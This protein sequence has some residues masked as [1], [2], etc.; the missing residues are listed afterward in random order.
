MLSN[1]QVDKI[2]K[3]AVSYWSEEQQSFVCDCAI[4]RLAVGR[5]ETPQAAR[6]NFDVAV[7]SL[8]ATGSAE[9][10]ELV[11]TATVSL[12]DATARILQDLKEA[13]SCSDE[14]A[15]DYLAHFYNRASLNDKLVDD[16]DPNDPDF[17]LLARGELELIPPS[18]DPG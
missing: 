1:L 16:F 11:V 12:S 5:G 9:E 7:R 10:A 2:I 6:E 4:F 15:I 13:F 18:D 8:V 17:A 14:E 3:M